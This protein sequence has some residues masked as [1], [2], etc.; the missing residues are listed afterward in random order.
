MHHPISKNVVN[1]LSVGLSMPQGGV[2][3]YEAA[4]GSF[5]SPPTPVP[6]ASQSRLTDLSSLV[7][8]RCQHS[9]S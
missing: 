5:D 4:A 6:R 2:G 3:S 7:S 9:R 8:W 1:I